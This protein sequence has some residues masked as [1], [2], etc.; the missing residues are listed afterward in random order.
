MFC[1]V[2]SYNRAVNLL[3][4]LNLTVLLTDENEGVSGRSLGVV[5]AEEL[6]AAWAAVAA[7]AEALGRYCCHLLSDYLVLAAI[8]LPPTGG[9]MSGEEIHHA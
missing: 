1:G 7:R 9:E 4:A 5:C 2:F 6:A 8:P 3:C